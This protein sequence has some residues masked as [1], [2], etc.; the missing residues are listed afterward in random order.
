MQKANLQNHQASASFSMQFE[1]SAP[2]TFLGMEMRKRDVF[3]SLLSLFGATFGIGSLGLSASM[4][5]VGIIGWVLLY[6]LAIFVNF[7]TFESLIYFADKLGLVNYV[8]ISKIVG[9]QKTRTVLLSLFFVTNIG[10]LLSAAVVYNGLICDIVSELGATSIYFTN[11]LSLFW[12]VVPGLVLVPILIKR[13]LKDVAFLTVISLASAFYVVFFLFISLAWLNHRAPEKNVSPVLLNILN[14]PG[15]F[16]YLLFTL[17]CQPNIMSIYSELSVKT[18]PNMRRILVLHLIFMSCIYLCMSAFGYALF[19]DKDKVA[20]STILELFHGQKNSLLL[21]ANLLMTISALNSF[22]FSFKP[23]KDTLIQLLQQSKEDNLEAEEKSEE[24]DYDPLNVS[25]TLCLLCFM[26]IVSGILVLNDIKF[27][28]II[29]LLCNI[30]IP[31]LFIFLPIYAY[32]KHVKNIWSLAAFGF[33]AVLYLWKMSE[34]GWSLG[35]M[36]FS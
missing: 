15:T 13:K 3:S 10:I 30:V 16:A 19:Y 7:A 31:I 34:Y 35:K 26:L 11:R 25:V 12:L 22:I 20:E 33:A 2:K 17:L 1:E 9:G 29:D 36:I 28:E 27:L 21:I 18:V 6:V 8:D 5:Q 14:A 32:T 4:A 23:L 24:S